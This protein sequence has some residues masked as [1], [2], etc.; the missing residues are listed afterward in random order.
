M[1]VWYMCVC[2]VYMCGVCSVCDG[3]WVHVVLCG[4]CMC[5]KGVGDVYVHVWCMYMCVGGVYVWC[6]C[7][8]CVV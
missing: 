8:V 1:H 5:G 4:I 6:I 2:G 7:V 3:V